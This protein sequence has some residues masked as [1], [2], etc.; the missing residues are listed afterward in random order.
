M[1]IGQEVYIVEGRMNN[2]E[3]CF[4][5]ITLSAQTKRVGPKDIDVINLSNKRNDHFFI[6][7]R[8]IRTILAAMYDK[9][10]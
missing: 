4:E 2:I 8:E 3:K 7:Q 6:K 10:E 5:Y 1:K 9:W